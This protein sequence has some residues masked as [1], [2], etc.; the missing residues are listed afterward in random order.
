[1]TQAWSLLS[2]EVDELGFRGNAGYDDKLGHWY[3]YDSTVPNARAVSEGD[4]VIIRDRLHF[5]GDGVIERIESWIGRKERFRCPQCR[6][7]GFKKRTTLRPRY[8][9]SCGY[10]FEQPTVE[11]LD[12]LTMYRAHYGNAWRPL[13]PPVP[14]SSV[15]DLYIS[16]ATQ[17][18]I[19]GVDPRKWFV[20]R[21]QEFRR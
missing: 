8:R 18:A 10:T 12:G 15:P 13:T 17:H 20:A 4:L 16:R 14:V 19:R 9:C 5:L 21:E 2:V 1:M 6:S 3:S 11:C 7:T